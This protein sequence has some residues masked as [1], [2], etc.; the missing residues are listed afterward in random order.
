MSIEKLSQKSKVAL[1]VFTLIYLVIVC[2]GIYLFFKDWGYDDPF[3]TFRYARNI[4]SNA[5]FVY[6]SGERILSTTTP[7]YAIILTGAA[8][9]GIKIPAA[10]NLLSGLFIVLGALAL[11]DLGRSWNSFGVR[12]TGLLLYPTFPLILSTIS[13]ETPI[14]LAFILG[15]FA[16]YA[17]GRYNLTGLAAALATLLRPDGIL[18]AGVLGAHFLV[19]RRQKIPWSALSL[20]LVVTG[21]WVIFAWSY[22]GSP[23]PVTLAAKQLQNSLE[24]SQDFAHGSIRVISWYSGNWHYRIEAALALPGL[25]WGILKN[26]LWLLLLGWT[27]LYF[28]A[29]SIL[30]VSSY[31]WYYAP[32]VPGFVAAIGLGVDGAIQ[33]GTKFIGGSINNRSKILTV[34]LTTTVCVI[35]I[36]QL[37]TLV[38]ISKN[39]DPRM[40]IYRAVGEWLNNNTAPDATIGTLEVGIIGF[41][42]EREMIDFAGLIQPDIAAQLRNAENYETAAFWA[43]THYQPDYLVLQDQ[44]FPH[45]EADYVPRYCQPMRTF[46]K[47]QFGYS[48]DLVV[49][50]CNG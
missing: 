39:I 12:L 31:F 19:S 5:G 4:A 9:S 29:Y 2:G 23:L 25:V 17:R 40:Q 47:E 10:A 21:A 34:A 50:R 20:F 14:Y 3:I 46:Q 22:F 28:L 6:N 24:V 16:F 42:A 36:Q 32:L 33:I 13:S 44:I 45:L 37:V 35:G 41:F 8:V 38:E 1:P 48:N 43:A 27:A 7:L 11:W 18:V 26:R 15:A 49:Y 30:G